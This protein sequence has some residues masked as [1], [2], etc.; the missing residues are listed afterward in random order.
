MDSVE[1]VGSVAEPIGPR[2]AGALSDPEIPAS[3][4]TRSAHFLHTN[5]CGDFTL[6]S[7]EK[8]FDLRAY[9][10]FDLFSM[11]I[12]SVFCYSAHHGGAREELLCDPMRIYHIEHGTGSGWTP[13]GEAKLFER[14]RAKGMTFISY[15]EIVG[16]A[17]QMR[18][19]DCP[20]IFNSEKWGLA[21]HC[22]PETQPP[23]RSS[24]EVCTVS[25]ISNQASMRSGT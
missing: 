21:D 5:G 17:A 25:E 1:S 20:F 12:D 13:E 16:W 19:M 4:R 3:Q 2:E 7:R 23:R 24:I 15:S 11:N 14:I 9:P 6:L 18:R 10:E 22:L 8:W